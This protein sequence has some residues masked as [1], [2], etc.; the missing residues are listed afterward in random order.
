VPKE[1]ESL[2]AEV[3]KYETPS[4]FSLAFTANSLM[5]LSNPEKHRFGR[6]FETSGD[7]VQ[8]DAYQM[9]NEY[10]SRGNNH[11]SYET[12]ANVPDVSSPNEKVTIYRG[13]VK[14]Q[15]NMLPGDFVSFS[16][17]YALNHNNGEKLLK[18][19]VPAKDVIWQGNDLHEWIYSPAKIR[20]NFSSL[21]DF[22][23]KVKA[24]IVS[25]PVLEKNVSGVSKA[26]SDINKVLVSKGFADLPEEQLARITPI[27]KEETIKNVTE[28][29]NS[30]IKKAEQIAL[31]N[32]TGKSSAEEQVIFNAVKNKAKED[33]N[34]E[35]LRELS[36]SPVASARSE[37]AQT[38]GASG[39]NN[40]SNDPIEI[41]QSIMKARTKK[42]AP[43]KSAN[44]AV[45]DVEV[46]KIV[47]KST[48]AQAKKIAD[49][50]KITMSALEKFI[51]SIK[52]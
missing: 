1:L 11:Y 20:K 21:E 4:E 50:S 27:T 33:S 42:N 37:A 29:L 38:L 28:L 19:T 36:Q 8:Q 49:D 45:Y 23:T 7:D 30:D 3:D 12:S 52:C 40:D 17:E 13:T 26:A 2:V 15:K 32:E 51:Q 24:E 14:A 16:K 5:D 22:Y 47:K 34:F 46:K 35:L 10:G 6:L 31:G 44:K 9:A 41:A 18:K 25:T 39:F 48:N 43:K